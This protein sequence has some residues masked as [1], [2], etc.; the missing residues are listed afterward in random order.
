MGSTLRRGQPIYA[1]CELVATLG[2]T[3]VDAAIAPILAVHDETSCVG[4]KMPL[5]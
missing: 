2:D 3:Q 5:A 4:S 1:T